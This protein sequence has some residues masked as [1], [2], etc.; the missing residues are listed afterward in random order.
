MSEE[1]NGF[2]EQRPE[3][4]WCPWTRHWE[5]YDITGTRFALKRCWHTEHPRQRRE[6]YPPLERG[7]VPYLINQPRPLR[8]RKNCADQPGHGS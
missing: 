2:Q 7:K 3:Q 8:N 6:Q 4:G 1:K 5:M